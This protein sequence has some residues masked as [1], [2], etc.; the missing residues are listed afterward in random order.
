MDISKDKSADISSF[1]NSDTIT[2]HNFFQDMA[3][4]C[5]VQVI[6]RKIYL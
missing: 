4:M 6:G 3:Y 2:Q 5:N 1:L